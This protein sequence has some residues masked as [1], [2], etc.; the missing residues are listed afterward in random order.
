M[1]SLMLNA[2]WYI[3]KQEDPFT[4]GLSGAVSYDTKKQGYIVFNTKGEIY[5]VNGDGYICADT[6]FSVDTLDVL[7]KLDEE[8]F[9]Q[10]FA[11]SKSNDGLIYYER[12]IE[13]G[14]AI[15]NSDFSESISKRGYGYKGLDIQLFVNALKKTKKL[16]IRTNDN[17]GTSTTLEFN[18]DGF[19]NVVTELGL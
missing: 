1:L 12:L 15:S 18:M 16:L 11:I 13:L 10:R 8:I 7:F 14:Y 5:L 9:S 6:E 2:E 4:G 19:T 17:C 3:E